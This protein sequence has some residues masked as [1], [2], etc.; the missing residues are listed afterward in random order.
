M[1]QIPVIHLKAR[2]NSTDVSLNGHRDPNG[3]IHILEVPAKGSTAAYSNLDENVFELV[4][5]IEPNGNYT[6]TAINHGRG[7]RCAPVRMGTK[8][9]LK[10]VQPVCDEIKLRL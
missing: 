6:V 10:L 7:D 8:D 9:D 2:R 4:H 1:K 5:R 3:V